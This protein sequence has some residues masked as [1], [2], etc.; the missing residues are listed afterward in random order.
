MPNVFSLFQVPTQDKHYPYLC[1]CRQLLVVT[2]SQ[3][4]PVFDKWRH[5]KGNRYFVE[6][7][8]IGMCLVFFF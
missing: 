6:C 7:Q 3:T 8:S 5:L 4:F 1:L 2:L